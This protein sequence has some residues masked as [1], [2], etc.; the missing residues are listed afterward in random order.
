LRKF[1]VAILAVPV[2][3]VVYGSTAL[4]RSAIAR[5]GLALGLGAFLAVGVMTVVR[6]APATASRPTEIIPL[7]KAAFQN[8]IAT[9]VGLDAPITIAFSTPMTAASVTAAVTV[10][11]ATPVDLTWDASATTLTITPVPRW[12]P[13]AY[14]TI[15]VDAGA[16]KV[17]IQSLSE[18]TLSVAGGVS[19]IT[20]TPAG[21]TIQGPLIKIN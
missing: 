5:L 21:I 7:T 19:T 3:A 8:A 16:A 12:N 10:E 6:P 9:G 18:I 17:T 15:T 14:Y 20:L 4:R 13:G 11:P 2:L 1:L